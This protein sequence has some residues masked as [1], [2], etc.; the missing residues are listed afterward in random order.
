ML[1][2]WE[3]VRSLDGSQLV[4][5]CGIV[6]IVV[7]CCVMRREVEWCFCLPVSIF[8]LVCLRRFVFCNFFLDMLLLSVIDSLVWPLRIF[9]SLCVT[10]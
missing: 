7:G 8:T 10:F 2:A 5:S 9:K 4:G 1:V 6:V 3:A